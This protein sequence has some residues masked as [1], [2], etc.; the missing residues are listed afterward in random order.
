MRF[1]IPPFLP[2]YAVLLLV[3]TYAVGAL[4]LGLAR[5]DAITQLT[6][7]RA[8]RRDREGPQGLLAAVTDIETAGR[9]Y[10][11]TA[12]ESYL[13]PFERARRRVPLL[14]SETARQDAR[15]QSGARAHRGSRLADRRADDDHRHRHRAQAR[16][17]RQAV[18]NDVRPPRQGEPPTRYARSSR[19]SKRGSR[20]SS[21]QARARRSP[22]T[23][24]EARGDLY[25][26]GGRDVAARVCAFPRRAAAAVVHAAAAGVRHRARTSRS[27]RRRRRSASDAELGAL[28]ARRAAAR[29]ACRERTLPPTRAPA[30]TSARSS[31]ALEQRAGGTFQ[32]SGRRSGAARAAER[33]RRR[34]R[35]SAQAYSTPGRPDDQDDHRSD[36]PRAGPAEGV[37]DTAVGRMGTGSHHAPQAHGRSHAVVHGQ[38]RSHFAPHPGADRQS[39]LAG[40]A[41]PEGVRGG[42]RAAPGRRSRVAGA[43]VVGRRPDRVFADAHHPGR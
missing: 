2:P 33:R 20:T 16:R 34:W 25:V 39:E 29:A 1:R 27:P 5:L 37:P 6:D 9:G 8:E 21:S 40:D 11:L 24:D 23:L 18:R 13:E 15:R 35:R 17:T 10:A 31:A 19:R 7:A 4:W 42:E 32:R 28:I 41:D 22:R 3:I 36:D 43:F 26:D 12:D 30:S 14:L 38:R